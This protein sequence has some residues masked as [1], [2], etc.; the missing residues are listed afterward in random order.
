MP[1]SCHHA[2]LGYSDHRAV[3]A[4]VNDGPAAQKVVALENANRS[5]ARAGARAAP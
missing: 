4:R 2:S 5:M 1:A 3:T